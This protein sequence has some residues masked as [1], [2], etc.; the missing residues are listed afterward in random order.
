MNTKILLAAGGIIILAIAGFLMFGNKDNVGKLE[1]NEQNSQ[2]TENQKSS[3]KNLMAR[4]G[5]HM[6]TFNEATANSTN[7][8]TVYISGGKMRGDFTSIAEGK[9]MQSH[10]ISMN[11]ESY[12]W[13]DDMKQG[14][15]MSL[16]QA[17]P[18][19]GKQDQSVDIN[20][21]LNYKCESW[22]EDGSKFNLPQGVTFTSMQEMMNG[23]M[24]NSG[25]QGGTGG[26]NAAQCGTCDQAPEP[27]RTQC[28]TA[29]GCK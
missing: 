29:L 3:L 10:M 20:A 27:Q 17:A 18:T 11:Q 12:V 14:F 4:S 8:G 21:E 24:M 23:G 2:G 19:Q 6:C 25:I 13:T 9:T 16:D 5:S 28:R 15:K 26:G 22:S 7:S 1:N